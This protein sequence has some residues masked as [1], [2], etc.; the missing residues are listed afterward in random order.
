MASGLGV[1]VSS[2]QGAAG[3]G[4]GPAQRLP[5]N[6]VGPHAPCPLDEAPLTIEIQVKITLIRIIPVIMIII[7][8]V[9]S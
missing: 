1:G 2:R 8:V 4:F 9:Y 7:I 6:E 3:A 5:P